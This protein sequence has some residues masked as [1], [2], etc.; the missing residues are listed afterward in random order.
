M[1]PSPGRVSR[2]SKKS[3]STPKC[4]EYQKRR[5]INNEKNKE[6]HIVYEVTAG[7]E[8]DT[9]HISHISAINDNTN[10]YQSSRGKPHRKYLTLSKDICMTE[11]SA[12]EL[13]ELL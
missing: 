9:S 5:V 11:P 3:E 12:K 13:Q 7:K 6:T 2:I 1:L 8:S 10:G 4:E